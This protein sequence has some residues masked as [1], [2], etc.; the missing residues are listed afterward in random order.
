MSTRPNWG[1]F[2]VDPSFVAAL[3]PPACE[4]AWMVTGGAGGLL[5]V[6]VFE[7]CAKC[8]AEQETNTPHPDALERA[9][10]RIEELESERDELRTALEIAMEHAKRP[11]GLELI[12]RIKAGAMLESF[13]RHTCDEQAASYERRGELATAASR[14]DD[15]EV[16]RRVAAWLKRV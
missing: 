6:E 10:Q 15:A 14:R 5:D 1:T 16:A 9:R 12:E 2:E 13:A 8:G 11:P 3:A 4:H 7:Q